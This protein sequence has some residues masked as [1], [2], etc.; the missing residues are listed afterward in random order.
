MLDHIDAEDG[1]TLTGEIP[2]P[3]YPPRPL[4]SIK[5]LRLAVNKS[6]T[7]LG[8]SVDDFI[9]YAART[10]HAEWGHDAESLASARSE[11]IKAA[12]DVPAY[13]A[14]IKAQPITESDCPF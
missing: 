4:L 10:W 5:E 12:F 14:R 6:L 7:E 3:E 8:I 13:I 1:D 11:L 9:P 2:P